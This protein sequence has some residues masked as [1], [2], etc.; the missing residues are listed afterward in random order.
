MFNDGSDAKLSDTQLDK[1]RQISENEF[2]SQRNSK[3]QD[4][5]D[6]FEVK[7]QKVREF[8]ER[9]DDVRNLSGDLFVRDP[10][11]HVTGPP[12][13]QD[14]LNTFVGA[15]IT[16]RKNVPRDAADE[17]AAIIKDLIDPK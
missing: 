1:H 2:I 7:E 3:K 13:S 12:V 6:V 16:K 4:Y 8:I 17:G 11:R 5:L 10:T 9:T 14:D 15:N